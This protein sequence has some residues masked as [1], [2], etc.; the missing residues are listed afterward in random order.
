M[1]TILKKLHNKTP[2]ELVTE[3]GISVKPPVDLVS[4]LEAIGISTISFDFSKVD[5]MEGNESKS[6][7]GVSMQVAGYLTILYS[8]DESVPRKRFILAHELGHL[9]RGKGMQQFDLGSIH[10]QYETQP[11]HTELDEN[12]L[13]EEHEANLFAEELLI[14]EEYL[15]KYY[16][17]DTVPPLTLLAEIFAVQDSVM[18]DRLDNLHLP[19]FKDCDTEPIV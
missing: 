12:A 17:G 14:P 4:L 7:V 11:L 13:R 10:V 15:R 6:I 16:N 1:N 8:K 19:Y 5:E 9:C 2:K 3:F 18:A